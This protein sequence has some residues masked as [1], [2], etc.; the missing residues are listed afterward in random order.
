M[1]F[2]GVNVINIK[3]KFI[4][5]AHLRHSAAELGRLP[6]FLLFSCL[7][8]SRS[9]FRSA[10]TGLRLHLLLPLR[11]NG[12]FPITFCSWVEPFRICSEL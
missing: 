9:S 8:L 1:R 3:D 12:S 6:D 2:S 11:P 10:L 7:L 5:L 4:W